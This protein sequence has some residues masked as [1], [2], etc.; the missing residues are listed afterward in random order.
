[1]PALVQLEVVAAAEAGGA[2]GAG[3]RQLARVQHRV[4]RQVLVALEAHAAGGAHVR[5][6]ALV[7]AAHVGGAAVTQQGAL[8]AE[9]VLAA[10]GARVVRH[11]RPP[12]VQVGRRVAGVA[13]VVRLLPQVDLV[14][15]RVCKQRT[16]VRARQ[17]WAKTGGE[18]EA[19]CGRGKG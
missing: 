2:H 15:E 17:V 8:R 11:Q 7:G 12:H 16:G 19:V 14:H 1:M 9:A 13:R 18:G 3:V 6:L 10:L 4:A 5:P